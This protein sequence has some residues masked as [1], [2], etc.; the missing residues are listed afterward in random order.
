MAMS[1]LIAGF[2]GFWMVRCGVVDEDGAH[3]EFLVAGAYV[4]EEDGVDAK[5]MAVGEV[6]DDTFGG[7]VQF[8][9]G[10]DHAVIVKP[11]RAVARQIAR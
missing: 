6:V 10:E 2:A 4:F 3:E 11:G 1:S 9:R 8:W 7:S 5:S